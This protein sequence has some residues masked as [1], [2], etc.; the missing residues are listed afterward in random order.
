MS[1]TTTIRIRVDVTNPG[2]YFAC[3]GLLEL[4]SRMSPETQGWFEP[5]WFTMVKGPSLQE[6]LNEFTQAPFLKMDVENATASPIVIG[7]KFELLLNWWKGG[8]RLTAGLKVWA[9]RMESIRI[10]RAMQSAM[11]KPE[12]LSEDLLNIGMIA[13]DPDVPDNKVEP[14]Y[15]DA[16]RGPNA[17]SRD[18]GFSTDALG[19]TTTASPAVE[20][21]CLVGIQRVRPLSG[22]KPRL[23]DYHTWSR[24]LPALLAPV[25]A[26]GLLPDVA[27]QGYRFESWFRTSQRKHKAF[28]SAKLKTDTP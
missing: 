17:H 22:G 7:G 25:A 19:M 16:R 26:A 24:P 10:A 9:G 8:D 1:D 23:Y 18:V 6:L 5:G 27:A 13:Y 15:F 28:L 4:A 11:R 12:F 3:C 14:F 2:H 21:L 20:L